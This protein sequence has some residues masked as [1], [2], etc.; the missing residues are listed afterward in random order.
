[1]ARTAEALFD[2]VVAHFADD[3]SVMPPS[4]S[5]GGRFGSS[6]LK[7]GDKLFAMLVNRELVVKL[8]SERVGQLVSAGTGRPFDPG[9]GRLM[10]EWVTI[11]VAAPGEWVRLA[12]EA[13]A[14]VGSS[15][16]CRAR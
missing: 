1:M 8:P 6:G 14:F 7:V 10:R 15:T 16:S 5:G 9:H 3:P 2:Q 11:G 13:R 4:A 12:D